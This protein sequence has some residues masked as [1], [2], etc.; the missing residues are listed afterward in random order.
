MSGFCIFQ[1]NLLDVSTIKNKLEKFSEEKEIEE[2]SL[3]ENVNHFEIKTNGTIIFD[4]LWDNRY[5]F[6]YRGETEFVLATKKIN[7]RIIPQSNNLIFLIEKKSDSDIRYVIQKISYILYNDES[8]IERIELT[9]NIIRQIEDEDFRL[10][11]GEGLTD[12]SDRDRTLLLYGSLKIRGED[13]NISSSSTH[14][15]FEENS[16]PYSQFLSMTYSSTVYLSG[17]E[18]KNKSVT[19]RGA[20][21]DTVESYIREHV[22]PKLHN[23]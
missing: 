7:V 23:A 1:S 8:H 19:L 14:E 6:P 9:P 4:Y 20:D 12:V 3:K 13:G 21:L 22:L 10:L 2:I 5:S 11:R 17:K 15:Q 18:R 16:K